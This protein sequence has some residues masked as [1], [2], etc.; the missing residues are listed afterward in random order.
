MV[1]M[2][3]L[4]QL[5][6]VMDK[7]LLYVCQHMYHN[8]ILPQLPTEFVKLKHNIR[9]IYLHFIIMYISNNV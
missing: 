9:L 4:V 7:V 2:A 8:N 1:V 5:Q 3:V 6:L